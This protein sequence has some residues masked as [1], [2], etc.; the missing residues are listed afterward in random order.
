MDTAEFDTLSQKVEMA[1][2]RIESLKAE[3]DGLQADLAEAL[4]KIKGLE[5]ELAGKSGEVES[6]RND[7]NHRAENMS[8]AGEQVKEL[9]SRLEAALA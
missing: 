9:V 8:R 7:L 4:E 2:K 6:L 1:V 3:R 5:D